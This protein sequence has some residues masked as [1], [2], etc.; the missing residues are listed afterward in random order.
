MSRKTIEVVHA[1]CQYYFHMFQTSLWNMQNYHTITYP[2]S[3]FLRLI[4]A[5]QFG[6]SRL[7]HKGPAAGIG[8]FM[9]SVKVLLT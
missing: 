6:S 3:C 5:K 8:E 9:R 7:G 1:N 2:N 4:I